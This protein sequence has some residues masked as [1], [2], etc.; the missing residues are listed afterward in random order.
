M[1]QSRRFKA[2]GS[3]PCGV[4]GAVLFVMV[5][6]LSGCDQK[7]DDN[8]ATSTTVRTGDRDPAQELPDEKYECEARNV[9]RSEGPYSLECEKAGKKLT[10]RFEEGGYVFT[11]ITSSDVAGDTWTIEA[12]HPGDGEE[13]EIEIDAPDVER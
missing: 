7:I 4:V 11:D 3:A 10:L 5:T 8:A 1:T 9:T 13:W 6:T 2:V 12:T